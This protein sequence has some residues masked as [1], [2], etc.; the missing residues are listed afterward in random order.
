MG[1]GNQCDSEWQ[2][3]DRQ[4]PHINTYLSGK[5]WP[6]LQEWQECS[7]A[8][9]LAGMDQGSQCDREWQNGNWPLVI[10]LHIYEMMADH[11]WK[12]HE[13]LLGQT[14]FVKDSG[15]EPGEPMRQCGDGLAAT[16]QYILVRQR[17]ATN[18]ARTEVGHSCK[19]GNNVSNNK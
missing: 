4:E 3:S 7:V 16:Y 2:G 15:N 18:A 12:N 11:P 19:S 1:Q 5:G 8:S 6:S 14:G 13:I 17:L 10:D 9:S